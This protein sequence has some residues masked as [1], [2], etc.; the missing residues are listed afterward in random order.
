MVRWRV[1]VPRPPSSLDHPPQTSSAATERTLGLSVAAGAATE[2]TLGL[3]VA[4]VAQGDTDELAG[5]LIDADRM[6][7]LHAVR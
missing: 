3:S 5:E 2:R 7:R 1:T 4:A 6:V